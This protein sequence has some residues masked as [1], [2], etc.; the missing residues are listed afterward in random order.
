M[1]QSGEEPPLRLGKARFDALMDCKRVLHGKD[2]GLDR[3][4]R[5]SR[6][7]IGQEKRIGVGVKRLGTG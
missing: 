4:D 2:S 3:F 7:V 5:G 1:G 6:F